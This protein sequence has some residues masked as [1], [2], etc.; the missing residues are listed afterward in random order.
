MRVAVI[1]AI[2]ALLSLMLVIFPPQ[3]LTEDAVPSP[4]QTELRVGDRLTPAEV[5]IITHPGRYGLGTELRGSVYGVAYGRLIRLD[6]KTL[7]VQS[8]MRVVSG[9]LD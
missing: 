7:R 1:I 6:E 3:G 5:H 8:I 9:V 2:G 4:A